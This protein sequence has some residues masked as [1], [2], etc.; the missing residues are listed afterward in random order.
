LQQVLIGDLAVTARLADRRQNLVANFSLERFGNGFVGFDD[1]AVEIA[2][3]YEGERD[4]TTA[5]RRLA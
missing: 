5:V 3:V 4:S 1:Q 2:F